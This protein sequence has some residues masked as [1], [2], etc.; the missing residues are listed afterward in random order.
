MMSP[1]NRLLSI[2]VSTALLTL[3]FYLV[4]R[5]RLKEKYAIIWIL[6]GISIL[7]FAIF[8]K[9]LFLITA[10]L[11]I[12]TPINTMF[13]LGIFFIIIINLNFSMILSNLVEQNKKLVQKIAL[14]ETE[15]TSMKKH[16]ESPL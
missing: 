6:T 11:G 15:V 14:L 12:K 7:I 16:A 4:R 3:I 9:A 10:L 1:I 13:F 8:D 2:G 5:G